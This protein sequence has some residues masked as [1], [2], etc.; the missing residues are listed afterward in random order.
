M[1]HLA[2]EYVYRDQFAA[3]ALET[4]VKLGVGL[5][6]AFVLAGALLGLVGLWR[7]AHGR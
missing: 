5:F 2:T 4:V 7:K 1:N 6:A 3:W